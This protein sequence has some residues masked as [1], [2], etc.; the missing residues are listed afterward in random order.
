MDSR[1]QGPALFALGMGLRALAVAGLICLLIW[2]LSATRHYATALVLALLIAFTLAEAAHR[3]ARALPAAAAPSANRDQAAELD[4]MTAL[5]DAVTVALVTVRADGRIH[6]A[7]RAARLLAG[8]EAARLADIRALGPS[9]ADAIAA[10]PVGARQ[11]VDMADGRPLLVWVGAIAMP[12]QPQQKL[13]S[14]QAVTGELDA[15]QLKAWMD[16]TRILSHEIM[17]SLTPIASLSESLG[18]MLPAQ[19]SPDAADALAAIARRSHHLMS[20][21]ERYRRIADL[22]SPAFATIDAAAFLADIDA[23]TGAAL[24]ARGIAW[25]CTPPPAP[26]AFKADP[27][28]LSQALINLLHNAADAV[29]G[30]AAP[31]VSLACAAE[32]GGVSFIV[33]DN[34]P[35]IA[36][37]QLDD[38][39]LPFFTTKAGGSGIGLTLARQIILAHGGRLLAGENPG[40]GMRFS[41]RL[42]NQTYVSAD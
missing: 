1:A 7:N 29:A 6:L 24:A 38:I 14:L 15:V 23:L 16:M 4:R 5:L 12:D 11:I 41:A 28:L 19:A 13:V 32:D 22:P 36:R 10:L 9:A 31:Q 17:N 25:R 34:G 30:R 2:D 18:R 40:G 35:G 21:V 26:L 8:G 20:F 39:F 33:S 27:A 3:Y 42:G 37:E